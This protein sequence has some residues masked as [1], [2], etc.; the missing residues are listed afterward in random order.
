MDDPLEMAIAVLKVL[1]GEFVSSAVDSKA[2]ED[3]EVVRGSLGLS[4]VKA[5][6]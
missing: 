1:M 3:K 6:S 4:M 2:T 5:G